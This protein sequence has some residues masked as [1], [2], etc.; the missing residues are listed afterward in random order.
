MSTFS[1][2]NKAGL[3]THSYIHLL[4]SMIIAWQNCSPE[5]TVQK[6]FTSYA[7]SLPIPY[8][9][10]FRW[11]NRDVPITPLPP[12]RYHNRNNLFH[13]RH[14]I[15]YFSFYFIIDLLRHYARSIKLFIWN[16]Q[17]DINLFKSPS[18]KISELTMICRY[19]CS[20]VQDWERERTFV[21]SDC[22]ALLTNPLGPRCT[23][24]D[25]SCL[26]SDCDLNKFKFDNL[27][28]KK[29]SQNSEIN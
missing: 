6:K 26:F 5:W 1:W 2:S 15:S 13:H 17:F 11:P 23:R 25:I 22:L 8:F 9:N 21:R 19:E 27:K 16:T 29:N 3:L 28:A 4:N 20:E 24:I 18:E 10:V 7:H 12:S 14:V